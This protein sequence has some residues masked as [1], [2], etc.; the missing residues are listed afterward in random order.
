MSKGALTLERLGELLAYE[1]AAANASQSTLAWYT[2]TLRRYGEWLRAQDLPPTLANFTL[3]R[4]QRYILDLQ[5]QR[6]R[7]YHP[8]MPPKN[9]A[10]SD[11]SVNTYV[12]ALRGFATWLYTE[13][14]TAGN[15][16]GRMKA[17][18][19]T[20]RVQ[21]IL[22]VEEI[23]QIVGSLNPRTEIGAR[24][25][26]IFLLL[27][28]TGMRAGELCTLTLDQ[29]HLEDG[30]CYVLG[31]GKKMR[32]VKVGG[33]AAKAVRFY[34]LHW[35]TPAQLQEHHVFLTCGH[36]QIEGRVFETQGGEPLSVNALDQAI[37]RIGR[38][39]GVPRLHPHLLRHTASCLHLKA[40]R[41]PFALKSLLGHTT[42]TMTQHY[43]AA[44]EAMDV[45]EGETVS[46][47]DGLESHVLTKASK[48]RKPLAPRPIDH[49][50]KP[51]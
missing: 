7:E 45:I 3:E 43:V 50:R 2:G 35:R 39:T 20:K 14:Y 51:A 5:Q 48:P 8:Y 31:K 9:Q 4:V 11:Q 33:R 41:D 24:D 19:T 22:T 6:A 47:V 42:L 44:V 23:G 25:Q 34:L 40:N 46:I 17:P 21:D 37:K 16:L 18:K 26:A 10:L 13:G 28:D 1:K 15:I 36:L 32:P 12:R 38:R 30:Y 49:K 27:L 29:L